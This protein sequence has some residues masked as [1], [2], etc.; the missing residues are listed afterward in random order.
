MRYRKL[1]AAGDYT[2]GTGNDFF[3]NTPAAVAQAVQ[4]RLQLLTGDWFL[5]VSEG[6]PWRT[7][8]LGKHPQTAY[9]SLIKAR[10]LETQGVQNIVSYSS[11]LDAGSRALTIAVTLNTVYGSTTFD[12]TL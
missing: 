10:I 6:T 12:A 5:D 4:T 9:D 2:L 1:D 7:K 3:V 11:T 8:I